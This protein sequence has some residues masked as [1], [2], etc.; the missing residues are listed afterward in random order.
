MKLWSRYAV[1]YYSATK[2]DKMVPFAETWADLET[3]I[4]SEVDQKEKNI[5]YI[6]SYMWNLGNGSEER[7]C[8]A[9]I[10]TQTE[11]TNIRTI[12][13]RGGRDEPGDWDRYIYTLLYK[14]D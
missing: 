8:K 6:N 2:R 12:Q 10:E 9:E 5:S 14:T 1:G 13:G 4:Q 7:T 3:V 11:R